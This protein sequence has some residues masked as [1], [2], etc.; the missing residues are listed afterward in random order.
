M[1]CRGEEAT[2]NE[3]TQDKAIIFSCLLKEEG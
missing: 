1:S 2:K 3:K